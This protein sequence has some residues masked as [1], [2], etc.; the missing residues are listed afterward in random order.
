[1]NGTALPAAGLAVDEK[2]RRRG[3]NPGIVTALL[4]KIALALTVAT[5]QTI[6]PAGLESPDSG[7]V[8]NLKR[9]ICYDR[10]GPS[11]G[12]TE[13]FLG[14]IAAE[15]LTA[16][17]RNS[18]S[19]N[20]SVTTFSPADGVECIRETGPCRLQHQPHTA[21]TAALYRPTTRPTGQTAEMRAI[22]YG[23]WDWQRTRY[24][25]NTETS[26]NQPGH[27][28]LRFEPDG[29]LSAQV[30][31]NSAGGKYQFQESRITLK[32]T[33]STLMSCQQGSLEEAFQQN[34]ATATSYF[35]K[36]GRL[37]LTLDNGTGTMEFDR[38]AVKETHASRRPGQNNET[39]K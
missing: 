36:D 10:Y 21:L 22:L 6:L 4:A 28:V 35:M 9:A 34:L 32:L 14:H 27:Y 37:F 17:Q 3:K 26:P 29:F 30:D 19:D 23:E 11:I 31:C 39:P 15:R 13:S 7:V 5:A 24:N 18:G 25:N 16:N 38:P 12:L 33:N 20:Q 2:I 1:M 8:C